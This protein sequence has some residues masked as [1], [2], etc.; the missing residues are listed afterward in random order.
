LYDNN[1]DLKQ[2]NKYPLETFNKSERLCSIKLIEGL[3]ETG[4]ILFSPL[5]K[6]VWSKS[7]VSIPFPAQVAFSASKKRFRHAVLRNLIKRRMREAYRKNKH[8]LYEQL[9]SHDTQ[10]LLVVIFRGNIVPD[11][12]TIETSIKQMVNNLI[13]LIK[14]KDK[15]C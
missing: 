5:I 1:W 13:N 2:K 15:I 7:P 11:Y 8:I 6:V 14:E 3:F 9:I 12:V 10:I 4:N